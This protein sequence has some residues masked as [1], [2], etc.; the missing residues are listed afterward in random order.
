[1]TCLSRAE[2]LDVS[3]FRRKSSVSKWLRQNGFV[4]VVAADGWARVDR[5]HYHAR[6]GGSPSKTLTKSEPNVSALME[7]QR[8]GKKKTIKTRST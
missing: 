7:A 2:L 8:N 6:M 5:L 4:F 3:G 1:M